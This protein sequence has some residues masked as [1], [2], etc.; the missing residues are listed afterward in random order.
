VSAAQQ[1]A[2]N[3]RRVMRA[4]YAKRA[5]AAVLRRAERLYHRLSCDAFVAKHMSAKAM[6][7][8]HV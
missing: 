1:K 8:S 2:D 3:A 5:P 4:L 6:G 7:G